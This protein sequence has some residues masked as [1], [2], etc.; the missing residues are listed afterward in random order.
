MLRTDNQRLIDTLTN[1]VS[2]DGSADSA[3]VIDESQGQREDLIGDDMNAGTQENP[4]SG[5]HY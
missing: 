2:T 5:M 4:R 3:G 1:R